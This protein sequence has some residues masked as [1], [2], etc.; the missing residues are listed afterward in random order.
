M[1]DKTVRWGLLG[2]GNILNRWMNGARQPEGMEIAAV[3]SRT[4][5]RAEKMAQCF[6]IPEAVSYDELLERKDIDV[7][8]IPVPH[9]AHKE[10]AIRAMEAG[11]GVLVEK[12]AGINSGEFREMTDCARQHHTFLMGAAWTR[13][14]PLIEEIKAQFGADGI[15]APTVL[16]MNFSCRN[17]RNVQRLFDPELGGG[18]LLDIGVYNLH[19]CQAVL[20]KYPA[21]LIGLASMD[22][23]G[24]HLQVDEQAAYIA[25][26]DT[27]ELA[28]M[29]SGIRTTLPD[30]AYLYGPRGSIEVPHF[31]KPTTMH[32]SVAGERRTVKRKVPQ[33]ISGIVDEGYQYEIEHVNQCIR[34]GLLE[35]PV[36]T[37]ADS[38]AVLE[39]CDSLRSQWGLVYPK[40]KK[41]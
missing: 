40:E 19:F 25:Q 31:W 24:L 30:T 4:R 9:T 21:R 11:K 15:G 14:F 1:K 37:W 5:E 27:G 33:R 39:Q 34:E 22:T 3:A 32:V 6:N 17:E 10:L 8:Y 2:A 12:P 28:M 41:I 35:S 26:Y 29:G 36:M 23:D 18:G 16:Q 20:Q 38:L 7:V 13:F